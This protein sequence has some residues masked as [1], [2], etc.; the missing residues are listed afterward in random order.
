MLADARR[1]TEAE[2]EK[3]LSGSKVGSENG[4]IQTRIG[5]EVSVTRT[6]KDPKATKGH[7][8]PQ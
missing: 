4:R 2:E 7:N 3:A 1:Y 6:Q 8:R 5:S